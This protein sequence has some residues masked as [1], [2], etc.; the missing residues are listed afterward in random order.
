MGDMVI[1]DIPRNH[2]F[3]VLHYLLKQHAKYGSVDEVTLASLA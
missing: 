2:N 3:L 1:E